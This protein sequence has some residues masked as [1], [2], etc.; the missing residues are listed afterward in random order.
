MADPRTDAAFLTRNAA[1]AQPAGALAERMAVAERE[2]RPLRVKLGI[3]PTA[4]DV[5]LGHVVVLQKLRE[6]QDLGH[7]VVLIIGDY[8]ARV[9]DPSGRSATRPV[10]TT[11]DID[12][13]ARTYQDQALRVL[14]DE[15]EL[16]EI[17]RNGEW[18]DMGMD[19][20]LTLARIPK[21]AQLLERDDFAK[22]YAGGVTISLLEF[23]YPLLQGYDSVAIEADVE[24]GGTDQTFNLYFGRDV[25][26]AEGRPEQS[27][28]TMPLLVG[29]DG[30]KKMSKSLGNH[31]GITEPAEEIFGR[32]MRIPDELIASWTDLLGVDLGGAAADDPRARKRALARALCDRF[33]GQGEGDRAQEAFDRLFKDRAIPDDVAEHVVADSGEVHLPAVIAS[34]FGVSRSEGRRAI[35]QGGVRIDGEPWPQDVLD[36]EASE[37]HGSVLQLGKRRFARLVAGQTA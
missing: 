27:V 13:N 23:V 12:R 34:A 26:R 31:I 15:P 28:I 1:A 24:I 14:R 17:R 35:T 20:F 32:T 4:P 7:R 37:L 2:G 8:T 22:R 18:L 21:V 10:L 19:A 29:T 16:L 36:A 25:Q 30:E 9:G 33:A 6:F 11:E 5:H 3:D